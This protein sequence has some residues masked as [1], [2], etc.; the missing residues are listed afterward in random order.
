MYQHFGVPEATSEDLHVNL[1]I[2][3]VSM[4]P[5]PPSSVLHTLCIVP[6]PQ[7]QP[8]VLFKKNF[9]FSCV[10]TCLSGA[11][12]NKTVPLTTVLQ[13]LLLLYIWPIHTAE[14]RC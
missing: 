10:E 6:P 9:K 12:C 13:S 5:D 4:S 14:P 2:S 11:T 3:W 1:K 7:T 8:T